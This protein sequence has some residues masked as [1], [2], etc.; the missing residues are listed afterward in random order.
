[1]VKR[2]DI[3][4][5]VKLEAAELSI[6]DTM[7]GLVCPACH[8]GQSGEATFTVTRQDHGIV[9]NCYRSTCDN[10]RGFVV[11]SGAL[12]P[13]K[14][15]RR[16]DDGLRPYTGEFRPIDDR[17]RAYFERRFGL[18]SIPEFSIGVNQLDEY[19]F[20]V[21]DPMARV[22]GYLIRTKPWKLPNG[23]IDFEMPRYRY[24]NTYG[25]SKSLLLMHQRGPTQSWY[26]PLHS[27]TGSTREPIV[28]VE[29]HLSAM[30]V[31]QAGFIGVANIGTFIDEDKVREIAMERPNVVVIAF[32]KDASSTAIKMARRWGL[33]FPAVRVAL[34]ERDIKDTDP[35]DVREVLAL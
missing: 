22:R 7:R 33:A 4:S 3:E 32:D 5:F 2:A 8:G 21:R 12:V 16:P 35:N 25:K 24:D 17:D 20:T 1:M 30:K 26:M 31:A 14:P 27:Y 28:I 10:G 29:D 15:D 18:T 6:G 34:L 9:Y 11:T 19:V 13:P 23:D